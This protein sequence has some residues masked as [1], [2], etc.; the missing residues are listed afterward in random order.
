MRV[1]C[2]TSASYSYFDRVR[3]LFETVR[4]FHPEWENW[5]CLVDED[6]PDFALDIDHEDVDRV[7]RLGDLGIDE[8][9]A[10]AFQHDV[11]EL[12]TAVKGPMLCHMLAQGI[13]KVIYLDPD[14]AL[15]GR[16]EEVLDLLDRHS[17]VLTPHQIDPDKTRAAIL[18]NEIG[19]LKYGIYNLG[20]VAVRNEPR[21]LAFAQW[22]RDRLLE[23]CFDDVPNGLFTDQKWCNHAPVFF[24][25]IAT[26][27]HRGYNVAS[28]NLS[29]RPIRIGV[30]GAITAGA[31]PLKFFHFTKV[32][33]VGELMLERYAGGRI[34]VFELIEWYKRR[35][36]SKALRGVPARWWHYGTYLNGSPISKEDRLAHRQRWLAGQRIGNPF[37]I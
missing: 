30:D 21:G 33:H 15:F 37:A 27:R 1:A 5:L 11:V 24:P 4:E 8:S 36:A 3:V 18:D 14:T 16:L 29:Q 25:E 35:L 9:L 22:W 34:E 31:D 32:T 20:F 28:W 10:W 13:D 6:P 17:A 19:S 7:V 12:C 26:L 23:F 2:F